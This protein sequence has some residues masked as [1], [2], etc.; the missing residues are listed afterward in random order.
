MNEHGLR[1]L[2]A[3]LEEKIRRQ[4]ADDLVDKM[5]VHVKGMPRKQEIED[6]QKSEK[7]KIALA[8]ALAAD[9]LYQDC[10]NYNVQPGS[11]LVAR[12][13]EDEE[14][15]DAVADNCTRRIISPAR[16]YT[17][18]REKKFLKKFDVDD[19]IAEVRGAVRAE[20][21]R[22]MKYHL[23]NDRLKVY[24]ETVGPDNY[25]DFEDWLADMDEYEFLHL[26]GYDETNFG[27]VFAAAIVEKHSEI[28][29]LKVVSPSD[30]W[31][32]ELYFSGEK[33]FLEMQRHFSGQRLFGIVSRNKYLKKSFEALRMLRAEVL[34]RVPDR[35]PDLFPEARAMERCFIVHI[36]QHLQFCREAQDGGA[37]DISRAA[38][39]AGIRA[40]PETERS[41]L[42][43]LAL[44]GRRASAGAG[45]MYPGIDYRDG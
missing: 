18:K 24:F 20:F 12:Y 19:L 23:L 35:M 34:D 14:A 30:V 11:L 3:E 22:N 27:S 9:G 21:I 44:H 40:I 43:L 31:G 42:P 36:G 28:A 33:L 7:F 13:M 25:D 1:L 5:H 41:G 32:G 6:L 15:F 37:R 17:A 39:F 29:A 4:T 38:A 26:A 45:C 10:V 8:K 16:K 2:A